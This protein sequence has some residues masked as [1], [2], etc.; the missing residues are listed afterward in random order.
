MNHLR[1]FRETNRQSRGAQRRRAFNPPSRRRR[2]RARRRA[3]DD[4]RAPLFAPPASS[5]V[6]VAHRASPCV[7]SSAPFRAFF[8]SFREARESARVN[9]ALASRRRARARGRARE[10]LCSRSRSV[11]NRVGATTTTRARDRRDGLIPLPIHR[12]TA[13]RRTRRRACARGRSRSP[14]RSRARDRA[15]V[16]ARRRARPSARRRWTRATA[17][18][19]ATWRS[20]STRPGRRSD[21]R[22]ANFG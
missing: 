4:A 5:L 8:P 20:A 12:A 10:N 22:R 1:Y 15:R 14:G 18:A 3:L 13:V 7:V 21:S 16:A 6:V 9:T 11:P 17:T 2:A 19:A